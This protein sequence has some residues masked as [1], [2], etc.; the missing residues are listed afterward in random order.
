MSQENSSE[1]LATAASL[2]SHLCD[3]C[4]TP[5]EEEQLDLLVRTN[6]EV[7][8]LY[9][10]MMHLHYGLYLYASA[11]GEPKD[12][13]ASEGSLDIA[14]RSD[15][16]ETMVV[17]A[18]NEPIGV[19]DSGEF[20]E[21]SDIQ[22]GAIPRRPEKK[23]ISK[24]FYVAWISAIAAVF[25]GVVVL[26]EKYD[27][28]P[29]EK[30]VAVTVSHDAVEEHKVAQVEAPPEIP[31]VASLTQL[32]GAIWEETHASAA[33]QKL[34]AKDELWLKKGCAELALARGGRAVLEG[35][36]KLTFLSDSEVFLAYGKIAATIPG[37]GF[38]VK[39]PSGVLRDLG[40]Q[41]G[42]GVDRD[43]RTQ[44]EVFEGHV[45][46]QLVSATTQPA[47]LTL[48]AG[49]AAVISQAAVAIDPGGA[50][51]QRFVTRLSSD[52]A[53]LDVVDLVSGGDG[54]THRR[55]GAI[56]ALTGQ[57]GNLAPVEYRDGDWKIHS[58]PALPVID[59]AFVPDGTK[60]AMP[61]DS[62]GH[63]FRFPETSN[64]S[65]N[66]IY[67]GGAIPWFRPQGI[68][69]TLDG[70]DYTTAGHGLLCIH[71][72]NGMTLDL[73]SIRRLYPD[74]VVSRFHCKIGNSYVNGTPDE[75]GVDP[76][77]DV[78]VIVDG[79]SKFEKRQFTH[80]GGSFIVDLP[81]GDADRFLT[82]VTTD[83]GDGINDDWVLWVDPVLNLSSHS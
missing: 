3:D 24:A 58:V 34:H 18:L 26:V 45:A 63:A 40:T 82:F 76:R 55:A 2:I 31:A 57:S 6:D 25:V 71:S 14:R 22:P 23:E 8:R 62:A 41:F 79:I 75:T 83:G 15:M 67:A 74:R 10:R 73:Q 20:G 80:Q 54:S 16:D 39:S 60:G 64:S 13:S 36:A 37:G 81:L 4:L 12:E 30:P 44:V 46:A 52:V 11:L 70:I 17:P 77:A 43:G 48:S 27:S 28:K 9:V 38:V 47:A 32:A 72:N 7:R 19:D 49:E 5:Q 1:L 53:Q 59:C 65:I 35:P 50:V 33:G 56:D 21:L 69:T 42:V 68:S 51:P 78:F 61:I 66:H 29:A